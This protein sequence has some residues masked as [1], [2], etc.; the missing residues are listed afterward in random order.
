ME[1]P[2]PNGKILP[3]ELGLAQDVSW[4]SKISRNCHPCLLFNHTVTIGVSY[5]R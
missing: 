1:K 4:S 5:A 3:L 2:Y